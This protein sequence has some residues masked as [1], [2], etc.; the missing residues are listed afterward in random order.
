MGG[1]MMRGGNRQLWRQ[2]GLGL[3]VLLLAG[4]GGYESNFSCKG[5][6]DESWCRP[7]SDVYANRFT[8]GSLT[9]DIEKAKQAKQGRG[10]G[11]G[12][13]EP[14]LPTDNAMAGKVETML[15]KPIVKPAR[16]FQAWIAPWKDD[17]R[18]LHEAQVVYV[19]V[20]NSEFIY[21]HRAGSAKTMGSKRRSRDLF[22]RK[23]RMV[24]EVGM[25]K[26][27]GAGVSSSSLQSKPG[28]QSNTLSEF[29]EP[30]PSLGN[31]TPSAPIPQGFPS[32]SPSGPRTSPYLVDDGPL[33]GPAFP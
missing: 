5:Y 20:E 12:K 15:G 2:V 26:G 23:G 25:R 9:A 14:S 27:T 16:T 10:D 6:A 29:D 22:P 13:A 24:E 3:G 1:V 21:G 7:V 8:P 18:R 11:N 28:A 30:G 17:K 31:Q 19:I 33:G 4:C 32:Q